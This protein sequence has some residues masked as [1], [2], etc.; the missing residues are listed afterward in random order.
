MSAKL[1]L[2]FRDRRRPAYSAVPKSGRMVSVVK[3][4]WWSRIKCCMSG[5]LTRTTRSCWH[6]ALLLSSGPDTIGKNHR[7]NACGRWTVYIALI[8]LIALIAFIALIVLNTLIAMRA[9]ITLIFLIALIFLSC[10]KKGGG[11]H[12]WSSE[13]IQSQG[14]W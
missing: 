5:L 10:Q 14:G 12:P 11:Q 6:K 3:D 13:L 9:L 4:R 2:H 8:A 7:P 1:S